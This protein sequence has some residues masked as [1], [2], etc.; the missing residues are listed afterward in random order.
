[1]NDNPLDIDAEKPVKHAVAD[2]LQEVD[3]AVAVISEHVGGDVIQKYVVGI[4]RGYAEVLPNKPHASKI[5]RFTLCQRIDDQPEEIELKL[6]SQLDVST[7]REITNKVEAYKK[8]AYSP[9]AADDWEAEAPESPP[10]AVT[11]RPDEH[12]EVTS[13][14]AEPSE[15]YGGGW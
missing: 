15:S 2:T 1:M 6:F 5:K 8:H 11:D 14:T 13:A 9:S 7:R 10:T 3:S 4:E 12:L